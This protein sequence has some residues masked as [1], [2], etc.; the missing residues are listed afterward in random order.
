MFIDLYHDARSSAFY[1]RTIEGAW[2][3]AGLYP[4]DKERLLSRANP[5]PT[6]PPS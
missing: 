3:G 5:R 2:R 1:E 6:T 4:L